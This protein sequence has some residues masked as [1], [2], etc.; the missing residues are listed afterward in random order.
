MGEEKRVGVPSVR[1]LGSES[2]GGW[3]TEVQT[4]TQKTVRKP[5]QPGQRMEVHER[6]EVKAF[7]KSQQQFSSSSKTDPWCVL[8]KC[9]LKGL[10]QFTPPPCPSNLWEFR[11]HCIFATVAVS[12]E[13][14]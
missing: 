3:R 4:G 13:I 1:S 12:F 6:R 11:F 2:R 9:F 7:Q 14:H 10:C 8:P 5:A